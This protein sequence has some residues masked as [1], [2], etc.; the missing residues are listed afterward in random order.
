LN[1]RRDS[2]TGLRLKWTE[3]KSMLIGIHLGFT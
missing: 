1:G 2:F 3:K